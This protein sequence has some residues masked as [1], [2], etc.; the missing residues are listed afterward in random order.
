M[1]VRTMWKPF[2][3]ALLVFLLSIPTLSTAAET[4]PS[5]T[6]LLRQVQATYDK[7]QSYSSVGEITENFSMAAFGQQELHITFSIKLARPNLYQIEWEQHAPNMNMRGAT[8]SAGEG[9]FVTG[10]GQASP[11]KAKD[12]STAFSMA[13][14]LSGG[15][16]A[17]I[18]EI[19]FGLGF[20]SLR[21]SKNAVFGQDADI[22]GDPCYVVVEKTGTTGS[23]LW[24]SKRSK[25]LRQIKEDLNGPMKVP[26]MTDQQAK[27]V[28]QS[29]GRTP[30]ADAIK[31]MKAQ[32]VI[33][34]DMMSSGMKGFFIQ[35]Q[36]Q[37]IVDGPLR[38]A[39][40]TPP[41]APASK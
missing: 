22:D 2:S 25:L 35:V 34:R 8:W 23:T 16:A 40:F 41:S 39:D 33:A 21:L 31:Q 32:M 6:D 14:G 38:K 12:M 20:N 3:V 36:R 18:P 7:M 30:T 4:R 13:T 19:F 28:L 24:I 1:G 17:T 11:A 15:A 9:N 26:E 10:P 29:M 5:A 27:E 37:I